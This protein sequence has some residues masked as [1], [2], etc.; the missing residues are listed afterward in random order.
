M[1][2][3]DDLLYDHPAAQA[4]GLT[5]ALK[6][7][8]RYGKPRRFTLGRMTY[9]VYGARASMWFITHTHR[10]PSTPSQVLHWGL[11]PTLADSCAQAEELIE[12]LY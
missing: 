11:A 6:A 10:A 12:T 1:T 4:D 3:L 8:S 9:Y 2:P 5:W 7:R